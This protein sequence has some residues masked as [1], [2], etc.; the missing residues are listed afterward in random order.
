MDSGNQVEKRG[1][2]GAVRAD[3]RREPALFYDEI[4]LV[5]RFE[6]TEVFGDLSSYD[7]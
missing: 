5:D 7:H 3:N 6:S 2:P 1:L 4:N